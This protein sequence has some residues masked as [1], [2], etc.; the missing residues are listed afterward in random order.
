[1]LTQFHFSFRLIPLTFV[2]PTF[3]PNSTIFGPPPSPLEHWPRSS[4]RGPEDRA[5]DTL[6]DAL[7]L[8]PGAQLVKPRKKEEGTREEE[9]NNDQEG[10]NVTLS[11]YVRYVDVETRI[12]IPSNIHLDACGQCICKAKLCGGKKYHCSSQRLR[13]TWITS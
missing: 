12:P 10:S 9:A 6:H 1:M 2:A 3:G 4:P 8:R 7:E 11:R 13:T 5:I